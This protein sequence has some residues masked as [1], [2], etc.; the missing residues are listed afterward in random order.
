M[1]FVGIERDHARDCTD[2]PVH[3][4]VAAIVLLAWSKRYFTRSDKPDR[5]LKVL[6]RNGHQMLLDEADG[7]SLLKLHES[8]YTR[9]IPDHSGK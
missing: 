1:F 6:L 7:T 8:I 5:Y 4:E 2:E 9:F 3:L